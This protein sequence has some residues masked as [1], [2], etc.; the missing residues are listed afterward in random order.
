MS[1]NETIWDFFVCFN[2]KTVHI[3]A[4]SSQTCLKNCMDLTRRDSTRKHA[5]LLYLIVDTPNLFKTV[6]LKP[7]WTT[8]FLI[9]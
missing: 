2:M 4:E 9:I 8:F 5:G 6:E 3:F 7:P 1:F